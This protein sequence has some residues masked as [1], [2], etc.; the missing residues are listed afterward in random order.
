MPLTDGRTAGN[1]IT[2]DD[3]ALRLELDGYFVPSTDRSQILWGETA[4]ARP[5]TL[6]GCLV[7]SSGRSRQ[8]VHVHAALIGV[9]IESADDAIFVAQSASLSNLTDWATRGSVEPPLPQQITNPQCPEEQLS[10]QRVGREVQLLIESNQPRNWAGFGAT[11][12]S[13][14]DLLTVAGNADC[15][16]ESSV[17]TSIDGSTVHVRMKTDPVIEHRWHPVF[18]LSTVPER[19]VTEWLCLREQLGMPGSV[20]FSLDYGGHGY[21]Q[22]KLFNAASAAEG[23]HRILFPNSTGLSAQKYKDLREHIKT[24]PDD[25]ARNWAMSA[26]GRNQPGLATRMQELA[27]IPD[28]EAVTIVLRDQDKW[29]SWVVNARN[30]IGHSNLDGMGKIPHTV[31]PALTYVTKTLLHLVIFEKLGLTPDQQRS[32][33]A[34]S[35]YNLRQPYN[36]YF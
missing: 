3:G 33:A 20:L 32:A 34:V 2:V 21:F 29:V 16:I 36:D 12:Q 4:D 13:L 15:R 10:L 27:S 22:N 26:I 17:L 19:F 28:S 25:E 18:A 1:L 7:L 11:T 35:Y 14:L 23:F 24:V 31:R 9:H 8:E 30:A 6:L 5:V